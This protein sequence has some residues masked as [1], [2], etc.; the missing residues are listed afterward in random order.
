MTDLVEV[1]R[2]RT[3]ADARQQALVLAAVGI[4]CHLIRADR[5]VGLYVASSDVEQAVQELASYERENL[6]SGRRPLPARPARHAVD[7][8]LAYCAVL[9]FFF[10]ATRRHALSVDWAATGAA[11]AGLI[12]DGAWWRTFTALS[13][14]VDLLHL[15]SNLASGVI[16]GILV[17]Q[18]FGSGVAWLTILLAGALGNALNALVQSSEHTAIGASTAIFGAL[19]ILS[20]YMRRSRVV[21]WRGGLRRWAPLAGGIMLLVF[22]GFSGERTDIGAHIAGFAMGG[23]M[24]FILAPTADRLKDN[25][26]V[27][28]ACAALACALFCLAWLFALHS[29]G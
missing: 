13:I 9:L 23:V 7:A 12:R 2:S 17:A 25:A 3:L 28:W 22:L 16:F 18:L 14:H 11:Q 1:G 20:G 29:A 21:P 8:A 15:M 10:G 6:P 24:G 26:R 27:Q 5:D 4:E 19:G